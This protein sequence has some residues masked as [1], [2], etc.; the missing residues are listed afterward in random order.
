[1][2][3]PG[4]A[5]RFPDL[6]KTE[7]PAV[8]NYDY[9]TNFFTRG[10]ENRSFRWQDIQV[11]SNWLF[12]E[13]TRSGDFEL[14][15]FANLAGYTGSTGVYTITTGSV[16]DRVS[17]SP[18]NLS[19]GYTIYIPTSGVRL[20]SGNLTGYTGKTRLINPIQGNQSIGLYCYN[21]SYPR[22]YTDPIPVDPTGIQN[23]KVHQVYA[24][25]FANYSIG[26]TPR[27]KLYVEALNGTT[28]IGYYDPV[29]VVWTPQR[30]SGF[31]YVPTGKYTEIK[32]QFSPA[33]SPLAV[34]DNYSVWFETESTG[35]FITVDEIH[36]DQ[37]ME[38]NPYMTG[39]IPDGYMVQI[40]PDL[41][42]H[43][44]RAMMSQSANSSNPFIKTFGPFSIEN[45][46]L[47]DNL[48]G[49]VSATIDEID[50]KKVTNDKYKKYL[51]RAFPVS[52]NGALGLESVP[53]SFEFI[54]R[55][56]D[57]NF[58]VE[59]VQDDPLTTVKVIVGTKS[60]NM[61]IVVDDIAS[62]G[63]L[64]YLSQTKWRLTIN[65]LME[66]QVVKIYGKHEGG[67]TTST[68]FIELKNNL[69]T[70][71]YQGLWNTFDEHGSLLDIKRLPHESNEDYKN[72]I[73]S[74]TVSPGGS[75]FLG[76]ANSASRE[77]GVLKIAGAIVLEMPKDKY[78]ISL[79][80]SVAVEFGSV[81][82]R[83]RTASMSIKEKLFVDPVYMT[84]NLSKHIAE[85]PTLVQLEDGTPVPVSKTFIDI[86]EE[87]PSVS[88]LKIDFL[89]AKGKF[90]YV[91]YNYY[92]QLLYK[93]FPTIGDLQEAISK[94][95][96]HTGH[97]LFNC[98]ANQLLSGNEDCLGLFI[99]SGTLTPNS[100]LSI[101]WSPIRIRKIS[102]KH[103]REYFYR[104]GESYR[105]TKFYTYVTELKSNSRTLWGSVQADRDFWDAADNTSRSFDHIPTLMDPEI[106]SYKTF[107][108][109]DTLKRLDSADAWARSYIGTNNETL[110]NA[111]LDVRVFQPGVAHTFD[112]TPGIETFYS[113]K[114][115]PEDLR[116][117]V[118]PIKFNNN[119]VI[120]SGQ[121]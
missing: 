98:Y 92:E 27:A 17:Y 51:W 117:S 73:R 69:Y 20:T 85:I 4:C 110:N 8:T 1:M 49:S 14:N 105:N 67:A 75:S 16:A 112:L 28:P 83:A 52:P 24:L 19:G 100:L 39:I 46:N 71:V 60:E 34:A 57:E 44:K 48:D 89:P 107:G 66:K 101:G 76:V 82:F 35:A 116:L 5:G 96:D 43:D 80:N 104:D 47:I 95:T 91:Q 25:A 11:D 31:Y 119:F 41:G 72:R 114:I 13:A 106:V 86:D 77:L 18:F 62:H 38:R 88:R 53:E 65:V 102:D 68:K 50:F 40:S 9:E 32:F 90:I 12:I 63:N 15:S 29:N 74:V 81:Y 7:F 79:H 2:T 3:I 56:V 26:A 64:E 120:F 59:E 61:T 55:S 6:C 78:S 42:W 121:R 97:K 22:I 33:T 87:N 45:G 99:D 10:I 30:P 21:N 108:T 93:D 113:R 118:S 109:G 70:P 54:G 111:G 94:L 84:V 37:F 58:S 115:S 23:D 36:L 103:F